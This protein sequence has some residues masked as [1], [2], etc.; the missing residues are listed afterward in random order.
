MSAACL[1]IASRTD[2]VGIR[3]LRR[4]S[5]PVSSVSDHIFGT[6]CPIFRKFLCMLPVA[7]ARSSS[8]GAFLR[9]SGFMDGVIFAHKLRLLDVAAKLW[10]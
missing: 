3:R 7:V 5:P 4:L 8:D 6:T 10:Q 2:D 9:I 1:P